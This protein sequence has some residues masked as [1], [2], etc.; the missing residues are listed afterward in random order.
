MGEVLRGAEEAGREQHELSGDLGV[1]EGLEAVQDDALEALDVHEVEGE[2]PAAGGVEAGEAVLVAQAQELLG[3]AQLGPREGPGEE[4]LG[5]AADVLALTPRLADHALR[6]AHGVG[7]PLGRVV[8]VVGGAAALGDPRVGLGA[9]AVD[10]DPDQLRVPPHPDGLAH[11]PGGDRVERL[12]EL[13]VAVGV[14]LAARPAGRIEAGALER[15]QRGLLGVLEDGER[16]LARG[17]VDP[18]SRPLEAPAHGLAL[19]V[20]PIEPG[21][22][23]EEALAQVLDPALDVGLGVSRQ[24]H[25]MGRIEHESSG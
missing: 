22:A 13:D 6:V 21:L 14:D 3:L 16:A 8:V 7:G 25:A 17:P 5:E 18:L 19:H 4:L 10:I 12:L 23:P 11:V 9:L 20:V 1:A 24:L 2:G 15:A